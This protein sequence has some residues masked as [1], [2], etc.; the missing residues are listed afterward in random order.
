MGLLSWQSSFTRANAP[1]E[2]S[3][4]YQ[5]ISDIDFA[6]NNNGAEDEE[7]RYDIECAGSSKDS[8]VCL[9]KVWTYSRKPNVSIEKCKKNAVHGVVFKG[10]SGCCTQ[11][12]LVNRPGA[13]FEYSDYFKRFFASN[14][15]Y[16]K[17]VD[18]CSSTR[19][20]IVKVGKEYKVAHVFT[21]NKDALKKALT[22]AGIIKKIGSG[23]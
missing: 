18:L 4:S 1:Y 17:Y 7:F 16:A 5:V 11:R 13:E 19:Q 22:E 23:L 9:V 8:K 6:V 20:E 2:A 12:A 15:E 14:G 3:Q 21:V 10:F